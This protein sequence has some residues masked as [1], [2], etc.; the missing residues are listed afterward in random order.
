MTGLLSGLLLSC[1]DP[2]DLNLPGK[3]DIIV[4]DGTVTNLAEPQTIRLNRSKA[5]P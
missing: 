2:E 3:V 5:D 1:V 4:V